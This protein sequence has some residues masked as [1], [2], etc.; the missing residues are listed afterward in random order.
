VKR[1]GGSRRKRKSSQVHWMTEKK[2]FVDVVVSVTLMALRSQRSA[3]LP[4]FS[5]SL[6]SVLLFCFDYQLIMTRRVKRWK[7]EP[8][9]RFF[10]SFL[11]PMRCA[12]LCT[13][14]CVFLVSFIHQS[15]GRESHLHTHTIITW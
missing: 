1:S 13:L 2:H 7:I 8:S 5:V 12:S 9:F 14:V 6:F 3:S 11:F 10:F 15:K 4:T